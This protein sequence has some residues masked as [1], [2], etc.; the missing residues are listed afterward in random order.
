[1]GRIK[2]PNK[3]FHGMCMFHFNGH[4]HRDEYKPQGL[5]LIAKAMKWNEHFPFGNF[6]LHFEKSVLPGNFPFGKTKL[7][8]PFTF[9]PKLQDFKESRNLRSWRYYPRENKVFRQDERG[10]QEKFPIF[11][12]RLRCSYS[13]LRRQ[14][15]TS[16]A[17]NPASYTG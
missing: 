9:Q 13:W 17:N 7:A 5:E 10:S 4:F 6:E 16:H 15:L 3:N 12:S 8:F 1:M 11:S 14:N 2:T